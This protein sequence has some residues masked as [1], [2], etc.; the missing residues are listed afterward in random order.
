MQMWVMTSTEVRGYIHCVPLGRPMTLRSYV[1]G[2]GLWPAQPYDFQ[3]RSN[4]DTVHYSAFL[5]Q[6][7]NNTNHPSPGQRVVNENS[8]VFTEW[9][10]KKLS[11]NIG[12]MPRTLY[13]RTAYDGTDYH[14]WQRQLAG[15]RTVQGVL[16]DVLRHVVRHPVNLITSG[17]TDAGVHAVGHVSSFTTT[18]THPTRALQHA[19]TARLPTDVAV[20]AVREVHPAFHATK[21]A[22]SKLYRYRIHAREQRP[23]ANLTHRYTYHCW[24]PLDAGKMQAAAE[25]FVGE[26]DFSALTPLAAVRE[27]F[28]RRVFRCGVVCAGEEIQIDVEGDGFLY[29]QVRTMAGTLMDVGY[30][31]WA[32]EEVAAIVASRDRRRAGPTAPAR[33]LCLQWV[34]YPEELLRSPL[35]DDAAAALFSE[36]T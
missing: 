20:L 23:V 5:T 2:S 1:Q 32:P 36:A 14:G 16:E 8:R 17:R 10:M 22:I 7:A 12:S 18:Y 3:C 35:A 21:S 33:G 6:A 26:H 9:L 30:G 34:K 25:H 11:D 29:H 31:R 28:V 19:I 13:L 4:S 24:R 15:L 27:C